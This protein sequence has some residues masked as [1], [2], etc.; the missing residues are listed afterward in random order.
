MAT[1]AVT[2]VVSAAAVAA[3]KAKQ[4]ARKRVEMDKANVDATAKAVA[5][6]ADR[7]AAAAS[8]AASAAAKLDAKSDASVALVAASSA[9]V[10]SAAATTLQPYSHATHAGLRFEAK[11]RRQLNAAVQVITDELEHLYAQ[12]AAAI[13]TG[14]QELAAM[15][16]AEAARVHA[17][18]NDRY[19]WLVSEC[20]MLI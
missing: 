2:K 16:K 6:A 13:E 1:A 5:A 20:N 12:H 3:A 18:S 14:D 7:K 19:A 15:F 17:I 11:L 8:A 4:D 10:S 9:A